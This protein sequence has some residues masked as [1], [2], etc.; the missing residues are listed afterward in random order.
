M[1]MM[2]RLFQGIVG[3]IVMVAMVTSLSFAD[4]RQGFLNYQDGE[5]EAA[6]KAVEGMEETPEVL[7]LKGISYYKLGDYEKSKDALTAVLEEKPDDAKAS[8]N[9]ARALM[10]LEEYEK[11]LPYAR[12]GAEADSDSGAYNVLGMVQM[13]LG[14]FDQAKAALDKAIELNPKNPWPYNNKGFMLILKNRE[15]LKSIAEEAMGYFKKAME[16]APNNELFRRNMEF[17][18]KVQGESYL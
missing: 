7:Y 4:V 16:L 11:A 14:N 1:K 18:E 8:T 2:R 17:M 3:I 6:L 15:D 12:Q 13:R 10:K 5:Y 9:L